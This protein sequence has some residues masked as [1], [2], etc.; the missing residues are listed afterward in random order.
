M[1]EIVE[2]KRKTTFGPTEEQL[3]TAEDAIAGGNWPWE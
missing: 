1:V 2:F 3:I